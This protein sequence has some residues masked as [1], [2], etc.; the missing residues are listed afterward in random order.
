MAEMP[1]AEIPETERLMAAIDATWPAAEMRAEGG[2]ILR[3]GAGGGQR[4]SAARGMG[5]PALAEA[6]MRTWGQDPIFSLTPAEA[7]L[8]EML[9]ARGYICHDPVALYIAP[10]ARLWSGGDETAMLLRCQS[11]LALVDE[12]WSAGGIGP[13]RRAIMARCVLPKTTLLSRA[14][15]HLSGCAFVAVDQEIAMIH[16]I[17]VRQDLRRQGAGARLLRG[18]AR[19]AG[20]QG[21]TFLALA[22][23]EANGPANALYQK[24]GMEV[25]GHYHYRIPA[26]GS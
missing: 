18:A 13:D 25:V 7:E 14:G 10:V 12:I 9:E 5:D 17:E 6:M 20:E 26:K 19:W 2:W 8:A 16:A 21:A 3:R 24:L 11:P 15:D 22:V 1:G 4:V 23:T